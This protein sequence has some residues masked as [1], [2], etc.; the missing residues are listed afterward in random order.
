MPAITPKSPEKSLEPAPVKL[1]VLKSLREANH[2][3]SSNVLFCFTL[4]VANLAYMLL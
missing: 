2:Y 1:S 4:L 3:I